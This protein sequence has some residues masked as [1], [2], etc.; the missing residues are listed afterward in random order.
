MVS[1]KWHSRIEV[2]S[3]SSRHIFWAIYHIA[4]I[5]KT[6]TLLTNRP[7]PTFFWP[8]L[9]CIFEFS[10]LLHFYYQ[11][12]YY[13][14]VKLT[15][16]SFYDVLKKSKR[17]IDISVTEEHL[18]KKSRRIIFLCHVL[19]LCRP[20]SQTSYNNFFL[21]WYCSLTFKST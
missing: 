14:S 16:L 19:G 4:R 1:G 7:L 20:K 6:S 2:I 10:F 21:S 17:L 12:Y 3:K 15:S 13:E 8:F 9:G 11:I 5:I 18:P